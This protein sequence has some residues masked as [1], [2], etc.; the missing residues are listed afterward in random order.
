[1]FLFIWVQEE[2]GSNMTSLL[3]AQ[4]LLQSA[5]WA[6]VQVSGQAMGHAAISS[7]LDYVRW[8]ITG[9]STAQLDVAPPP[10]SLFPQNVIFCHFLQKISITQIPGNTNLSLVFSYPRA[11]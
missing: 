6:K 10:S 8:Q 3:Q 5:L 2:L 7:N 11:I 9:S 4:Q 1:M